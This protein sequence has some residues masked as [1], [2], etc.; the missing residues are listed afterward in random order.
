M[1]YD[2]FCRDSTKIE[3]LNYPADTTDIRIVHLFNQL[4]L[5][6]GN[7]ETKEDNHN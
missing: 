1:W 4:R 6:E 2:V 3:L 7:D 5:A